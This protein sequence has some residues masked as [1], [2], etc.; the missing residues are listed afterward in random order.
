LLCSFIYQQSLLLAQRNDHLCL[1]ALVHLDNSH[2]LSY[3][4]FFLSDPVSSVREEAARLLGD[5]GD[6]RAIDPLIALMADAER[7]VRCQ[8]TLALSQIVIP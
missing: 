4:L 6:V 3:L 1:L 5:L 8:A 2:A 7:S